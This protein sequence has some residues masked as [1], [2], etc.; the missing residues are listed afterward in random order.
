MA[1]PI[2]QVDN[3]QTIAANSAQFQPKSLFGKIFHQL[4][5]SLSPFFKNT[6]SAPSNESSID[7]TKIVGKLLQIKED[8]RTQVGIHLF[9]HLESAIDRDAKRIEKFAFRPSEQ[10]KFNQLTDRITRWV[11]LESQPS[12]QVA[13]VEAII[14]HHFQEAK[15]HIDQDLQ[16]IAD[17]KSDTLENLPEDVSKEQIEILIE[18][19]L[20]KHIEAL[21]QLKEM[22]ENLDLLKEMPENLDLHKI[23]VWKDSFDQQR[24]HHFNHAIKKIDTL[25]AQVAPQNAPVPDDEF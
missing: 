25:I 4:K 22:P 1:D 6:V 16:M 3:L 5:N 8:L 21:A 10:K 9:K 17:I 7:S 2:K 23:A 24:A 19:R 11:N 18:S 20:E 13:I 14:A 12:N 15:M